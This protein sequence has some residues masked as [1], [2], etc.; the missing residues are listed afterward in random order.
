MAVDAGT[1]NT[2]RREN[3]DTMDS[4]C[5]VQ[6]THEREFV[7]GG[8][9]WADPETAIQQRRRRQDPLSANVDNI[10]ACFSQ[11][12]PSSLSCFRA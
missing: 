4:C 12:L 7:S 5:D 11:T 2:D 1:I 8:G 10:A 6:P 9:W 3:R